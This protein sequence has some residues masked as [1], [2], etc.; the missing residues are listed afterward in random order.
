MCVIFDDIYECLNLFRRKYITRLKREL[1]L[2][3]EGRRKSDLLAK[4]ETYIQHVVTI[5][6]SYIQNTTV[7]EMLHCNW[8]V[9]MSLS[10]IDTTV[11]FNALFKNALN[12]ATT[13]RT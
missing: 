11:S 6:L 3:R 4:L 12:V 5:L 7:V 8:V 2:M 13:G 1:Q 10:M 9:L